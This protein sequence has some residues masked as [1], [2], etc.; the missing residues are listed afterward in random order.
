MK[1][2]S[3][4]CTLLLV[5]L[6][7]F[8]QSPD[9]ASL[10][11]KAAAGDAGSQLAL[12]LAYDKGQGV[13]QNDE[14]AAKWY[15]AAAELGNAEAQADLGVMYR[16]GRGVPRDKEEAV[17]WYSKA[18]I[19]GNAAAM[20]NLAVSYY[21]GDGVPISDT[22]AYAW[23]ALASRTGN[24]DANDALKRMQS[25]LPPSHVQQAD[26]QLAT[27]LE[28]S[29]SAISDVKGAA[30]VYTRLAA[31]DNTTAQIRLA[32]MYND[33]RGV[34]QDYTAMK[35]WCERA[36]KKGFS[37]GMFCLGHIT[38]NGLGGPPDSK[39]ATQ[40]YAKAANSGHPVAMYRLGLA[41]AK[42]DGVKR[43]QVTAYKWLLAASQ[44]K[45]DGAKAALEELERGMSEK[46]LK[47]AK[48]NPIDA[49]PLGLVNRTYD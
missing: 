39:A 2:N 18:A 1:R 41:Y 37:P 31:Q 44:N 35:Y 19:Q 5:S 14:L 30:E 10:K 24:T 32:Y 16:L 34:P 38:Q 36:S 26:L 21:N 22:S 9:I 29:G 8:A 45:V 47:K 6:A 27:L 40:W 23:F 3:V 25:E 28:Q 42:G 4:L 33:G 15:R 11:S 48:Q 49:R 12:G 13:S 46:D 17:K 7:A 20:Y 43:D